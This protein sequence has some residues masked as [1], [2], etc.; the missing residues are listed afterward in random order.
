MPPSITGCS[1]AAR[2]GGTICRDHYLAMKRWNKARY[3]YA[4]L[5]DVTANP[6]GPERPLP[7]LLVVGADEIL[8]SDLRGHAAVRLSP[9]LYL[10]TE[11]NILRGFRRR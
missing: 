5:A 6:E 3:G 7:R 11:G 4:D 2:N 10:S 9:Q 8:L 1:T